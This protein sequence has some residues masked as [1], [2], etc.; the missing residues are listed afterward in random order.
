[1]AS[2]GITGTRRMDRCAEREPRSPT[3]VESVDSSRSPISVER[4][5]RSRELDA[6]PRTTLTIDESQIVPAAFSLHLVRA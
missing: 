4:S 5:W 6:P 2:G 3:V 1:M